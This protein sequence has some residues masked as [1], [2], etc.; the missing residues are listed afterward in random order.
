[1]LT[2]SETTPSSPEAKTLIQELDAELRQH[3]PPE[4]M[5]GLT[6]EELT[7]FQGVFL[8]ARL[9]S[10]LVGCGALRL[11]G[12]ALGEIKRMYV[13]PEARRHGVARGLLAALETQAQSLAMTVVRLETGR[14]QKAAQQL[15]ESAGYKQIECY[16]EYAGGP[17]SVCYEKRL[18][19]SWT[20][21]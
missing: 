13:C 16:G 2:I 3:Y 11:L 4:H 15:Y 19:T 12:P 7:H 6:A 14:F 20:A 17:Y 18:A 1:M 5:H 10:K 9:N 8:I 21:V